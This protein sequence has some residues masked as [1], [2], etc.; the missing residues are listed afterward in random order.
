MSTDKVEA[1]RKKVADADYWQR[2]RRPEDIARLPVWAVVMAPFPSVAKY[3]QDTWMSDSGRFGRLEVALLSNRTQFGIPCGISA[4]RALCL[5]SRALSGTKIHLGNGT[6]TLGELVEQ[7]GGHASGGGPRSGREALRKAIQAILACHITYQYRRPEDLGV[8]DS[9]VVS[10]VLG[11]G[12]PDTLVKADPLRL[13]IREVNPSFLRL[14]RSG[15]PVDMRALRL[16]GRDA[17]TWDLLNFLAY[18]VRGVKKSDGILL[19]WEWLADQMGSGMPLKS[20][21]HHLTVEKIP[22]VRVLYPNLRATTE[23]D[24]VRLFSS[25]DFMS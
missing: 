15:V 6:K 20:F 12:E 19:L 13:I 5:I 17:T 21:K 2:E 7:S 3:T 24:G 8:R 16:V 11:L 22:K 1:F 4:R 10:P 18:R 25:D 14:V 9:L 23:V